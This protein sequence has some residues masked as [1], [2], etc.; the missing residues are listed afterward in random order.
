MRIAAVTTPETAGPDI[1]IV[2]FPYLLFCH[3]TP[4]CEWMSRKSRASGNHMDRPEGER[5]VD[6]G[7]VTD[8]VVHPVLGC[9]G[10]FWLLEIELQSPCTLR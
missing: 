5:R 4:Q 9:D 3:D 10:S 6:S 7:T 8:L 1:A 2:T